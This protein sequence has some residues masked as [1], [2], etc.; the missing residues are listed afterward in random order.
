[1]RCTVFADVGNERQRGDRCVAPENSFQRAKYTE[2][3]IWWVPYIFLWKKGF[4]QGGSE[5]EEKEA[6]TINNKK[7]KQIGNRLCLEK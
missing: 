7:I 2:F 4:E 6:S 3:T 1:M 5:A